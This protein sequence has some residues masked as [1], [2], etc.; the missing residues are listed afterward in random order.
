LAK[1]FYKVNDT[2]ENVAEGIIVH[3]DVKSCNL[4]WKGRLPRLEVE[5]F[6][7]S[8]DSFYKEFLVNILTN[9]LRQ[10]ELMNFEG[11][12]QYDLSGVSI[13]PEFI[14][15][16][17]NGVCFLTEFELCI[18]KEGKPFAAIELK[19][20]DAIRNGVNGIHLF[21]DLTKSEYEMLTSDKPVG[22]LVKLYHEIEAVFVYVH[23]M[24]FSVKKATSRDSAM[25]EELYSLFSAIRRVELPR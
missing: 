21:A 22:L 20:A 4:I 9:G 11:I 14:Y 13:L 15:S 5:L 6:Y 24:L 23:P 12:N 16:S 25:Y 18:G 7:G 3:D 19:K 10:T 8:G 17:G 2:R 1:V